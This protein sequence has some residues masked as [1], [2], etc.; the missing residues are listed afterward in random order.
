M[1]HCSL[2]VGTIFAKYHRPMAN[3]SG[4]FSSTS[5]EC[6]QIVIRTMKKIE[7]EI[8]FS[9]ATCAKSNW[10]ILKANWPSLFIV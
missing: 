4:S 5:R 3:G 9:N 1:L 2:P 7:N 8:T 6:D 10:P